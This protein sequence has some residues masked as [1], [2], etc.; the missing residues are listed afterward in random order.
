MAADLQPGRFRRRF[1][2]RYGWTELIGLR[3]P[4]ASE[5]LACGFLLLGAQVEY[6][7]H[8]HEAEEIY[9]ALAGRALW[10]RGEGE[11]EPRAPGSLIRHAS[12]ET[13]AMITRDEPL[14]A[15]YMWRGGDLA[16]KSKIVS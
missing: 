13:H 8:A 2:E 10:R 5:R 14:L 9:L 1:L 3:G 7:A 6:P 12:W 4:I 11:F 16:A 15:L